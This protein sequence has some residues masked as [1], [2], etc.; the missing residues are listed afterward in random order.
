MTK[1]YLLVFILLVPLLILVSGCRGQRQDSLIDVSQKRQCWA[2]MN[3]L[4]TDMANYRDATGH[5][6][7]NM[8]ELDQYARRTRPM[9]CPVTHEPYTIRLEEDGYV[10]SCPCGHGSV[11][12]GRRSWTGGRD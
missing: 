11:D 2:N 6:T 7:D 5:W 12:T 9:T 10:L 4:S 8:E 3:I 1:R